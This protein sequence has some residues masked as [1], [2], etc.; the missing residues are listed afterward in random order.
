MAKK[1]K[2]TK[3]AIE[4]LITTLFKGSGNKAIKKG[5]KAGVNT[6]YF[7]ID[8]TGNGNSI[9]FDFDDAVK[10]IRAK[11]LA[12]TREAA[13][14]AAET[15][16]DGKRGLVELAAQARDRD[17][18][19]AKQARAE[20]EAAAGSEQ[21][22]ARMKL[23]EEAEAKA[24]ISQG[25]FQIL[26]DDSARATA[27]AIRRRA[28]AEEA[29]DKLM[30][31]AGETK[32]DER[33]KII[34]EAI[35]EAEAKAV[36]IEYEQRADD[37]VAKLT[38]A[39]EEYEQ[40]MRNKRQLITDLNAAKKR[41]AQAELAAKRPGADREKATK[42]VS[43]ADTALKAI[44][45]IHKDAE[46][47][48]A[49]ARSIK[50]KW[51]KNA[52]DFL[53]DPASE[54]TP[55]QREAVQRA[56]EIAEQVGD[57]VALDKAD[58]RVVNL[59]DR[60]DRNTALYDKAGLEMEEARQA[61]IK[62]QQLLKEAKQGEDE[63][64]QANAKAAA[65]AY[66]K[67]SKKFLAQRSSRVLLRQEAQRVLDEGVGD[68]ARAMI[69]GALNASPVISFQERLLEAVTE[70][71]LDYIKLA[72]AQQRWREAVANSD[73]SADP[74]IEEAAQELQ[75]AKKAL[76]QS[77]SRITSIQNGIRNALDKPN[78]PSGDREALEAVIA[79][80]RETN[81][82]RQTIYVLDGLAEAHLKTVSSTLAR[83]EAREAWEAAQR[84]LEEIKRVGGD[85]T[86][87]QERVKQTKEA[88]DLAETRSHLDSSIIS[89][90]ERKY[91]E[92]IPDEQ[93]V[94]IRLNEE[95]TSIAIKLEQAVAHNKEL[96]LARDQVLLAQTKAV[97]ELKQLEM[98]GVTGDRLEAARNR[99]REATEIYHTANGRIRNNRISIETWSERAND[100]LAQSEETFLENLNRVR[101]QGAITD[102]SNMVRSP[103]E[104]ANLLK[105]TATQ[106]NV[107]YDAVAKAHT[108]MHEAREYLALARQAG[109]G[110][111][112]AEIAF[113]EAQTLLKEAEKNVKNI[114][115]TFDRWERQANQLLEQDNLPNGDRIAI[116]ES[117]AEV[118]RIKDAREPEFIRRT[119]VEKKIQ[120]EE[121]F[122][123]LKIVRETRDVAQANL[124]KARATGNKGQ[125]EEAQTKLEQA[126]DAFEIAYKTDLNRHRVYEKWKRKAQAA[127]VLAG[128]V[129]LVANPD[130][131][132]ASTT[133]PEGPGRDTRADREARE[134]AQLR[135]FAEKN[136]LEWQAASKEYETAKKAIFPYGTDSDEALGY[137]NE[138]SLEEMEALNQATLR[139]EKAELLVQTQTGALIEARQESRKETEQREAVADH[140]LVVQ[141][142]GANLRQAQE[143]L[144]EVTNPVEE[145]KA[146]VGA[147]E[148]LAEAKTKMA[149]A[150][151]GAADVAAMQKAAT[152]FGISAEE[153]ANS[154]KAN[155][156]RLVAAK[157]QL[158]EAEANNAALKAKQ[159]I[160][161]PEGVDSKE[162][163]A[164]KQ[165]QQRVQEAKF[166]AAA[167]SVNKAE[168]LYVNERV[169]LKRED[170]EKGLGEWSQ[171]VMATREK[172]EAQ[173]QAREKKAAEGIV[174]PISKE[175][176]ELGL[177]Y[178][179]KTGVYTNF[180]EVPFA[181]LVAKFE[182][183]ID[184][185]DPRFL[186][187][188]IKNYEKLTWEQKLV[189]DEVL[190]PEVREFALVAYNVQEAHKERNDIELDQ[191]ASNDLHG[192]PV[193][194]PDQKGPEPKTGPRV[195]ETSLKPKELGGSKA[196]Q[197]VWQS[198]NKEQT[199]ASQNFTANVSESPNV[200]VEVCKSGGQYETGINT[201]ESME[202]TS[203]SQ[204]TPKVTVPAC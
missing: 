33:K 169:R 168:D 138:A 121:A 99:V 105:A 152:S 204:L 171:E 120:S 153:L 63:V 39:A 194:I 78:M 151:A 144:E 163:L 155:E 84:N 139:L 193:V 184:L 162:L 181:N 122:I 88:Y 107:E 146:L 55:S 128:V 114:S 177:G 172:R 16:A 110:I 192:S 129:G 125:I 119:L 173:R 10:L 141:H 43:E 19:A 186:I 198:L 135:A 123:A 13:A 200:D 5:A 68:E 41:L 42:E 115:F 170:P 71:D 108:R 35:K 167:V 203:T 77:H 166:V 45:A 118:K 36:Q 124:E 65:D 145:L 27:V 136:N 24:E 62:A 93:V 26:D 12:E 103:G 70:R 104:V 59:I 50:Y 148:R 3:K 46:K 2:L 127:G 97:T 32:A 67:A 21:A 174:E 109:E 100:L 159:K 82:E 189:V 160:V 113:R 149:E 126:Q 29:D 150:E 92:L 183:K 143:K 102:A 131:A 6:G 117:L 185:A 180:D 23:A 101:L 72:Q 76:E 134:V 37:I 60:L 142:T 14:D 197:D 91:E 49:K 94:A 140:R 11:T 51:G 48:V 157:T 31:V 158:R 201:E 178:D 22:E 179:P 133:K 191:R 187:E 4:G 17:R 90:W 1:S 53:A 111:E 81:A 182:D 195:A 54:L 116:Q 64:A 69:E 156:E 199:P 86:K 73:V 130:S 20:A 8:I 112:D 15:L 38:Q 44:Q 176:K 52:D 85:T 80:A 61:N 66:S 79:T 56:K 132:A 40:A 34:D 165:V 47:P 96:I 161:L 98:E 75:A 7:E 83:T 74:K 87:A 137:I 147:E 58:K 18:T 89:H 95:A 25:K 106:H 196:R 164:G 30:A 57:A 175:E 154:Q 28:E 9:P 202:Q 188:L 190:T